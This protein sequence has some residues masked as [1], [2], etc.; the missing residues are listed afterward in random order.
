MANLSQVKREQ[1][2]EFLEKIKTQHNDDESLIAL[3]QIEKELTAKK[4]GLVWEEHDENVYSMMDKYIPV[5][6]EDHEREIITDQKLPYNF[7]IEGDN[8]HSLEVLAKTHKH[9]IDVIYIDPPYNTGAKDWKYNN[10][11]VDKNDTY[12]HSKWLSMMSS[13]MKIAFS[14]LK[15]DGV[16]ICAIDENEL[17]TTLLLIEDIFGDGYKADPIAVIHNPRGVQGDNFSYVNEYAIFVYRKGYKVV[18]ERNVEEEEI[19]WSPLRN[20]GSESERSDARNCFYPVYIK[21]DKIVGF[22]DVTPNEIHPAQ[23][24]YDEQSSTYAVYPID[25]KGVERKWRYARQSVEGI[26]HLLRAKKTKN[27]YDIEIGKNYAPYKTVWTDKKYD[28]NEYGTQL[29]G[30]MIPNNEF[31]FPK[32]VYTVYDCLFA[33]LQNRKNAVVLDYFAGSGTTGH[34]VLML[35]KNTNNN[36]RFILCTNNDVGEAREKEFVK[37]YGNPDD[38]EKEWLDWKQQYGIASSATYPRIKSAIKGFVHSKDFKNTLYQKRLTPAV[39][40]GFEKVQ[41]EI[42]TI[43]A[44]NNSKYDEIN[45]EVDGDT[46]VVQGIIKKG[47]PVEGIPA[48]L[49][50]YQ[51]EFIEKD[52]ESLVDDLMLF[53]PEMIQLKNAVN[54]ND[55]EFVIVSDDEEMD[56]FEKNISSYKK[57]K[58]VY[59]SQDVLLSAKQENMLKSL[60]AYIVPDCYFDSELREAGEIW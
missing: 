35:N 23:T 22:G 54:L 14:L 48:N 12:R 41:K 27:G 53:V 51:T 28:A 29:I 24:E 43:V 46:V 18:G 42:D 34:A 45:T 7:I 37:K 50:Y 26:W 39:L 49:K 5:V 44:A 4:F 8:L 25:V 11:Y 47:N 31:T 40:K 32:S 30:S 9:S 36:H 57:L 17:G 21:D 15:D 2:I 52:T 60:N 10:D 6:R 58:G 19:D 56:A 38:Y 59:I 1:M 20:W 33:V 16:F 13:R 3:N 55:G